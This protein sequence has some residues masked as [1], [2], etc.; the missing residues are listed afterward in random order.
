M[1]SSTFRDLKQHR[2]AVIAAMNGEQMIPLAQ[3]FDGALPADLIKSSL[4]KVEQA[5]VYVGMIASRYGQRPYCADRN[6]Q[7]LSLTELEYRR[8]AERKLPRLMFIMADDHPLTHSDLKL[9]LEEGDEA[10]QLQQGFV[11]LVLKDGI[12]AEFSSPHDLKAQ[13]TKTFVDFLKQAIAKA[14]PAPTSTAPK[15]QVGPDETL[16]TPPPA[17]HVVRKPYVEKRVFAGRFDELALIDA[18]ATGPDTMLLLQA[19]GG[20]GKSM[21]TWHWLKNYA[22]QV[23]PNWAGQLWYSFYEHGADLNDFLVHALAYIRQC[24]PATLR[25]M[26]TL[27]LGYALRQELHAR[28]WLLIL[29]GLERVLVAYNRAG[30]EHMSDDDAEVAR[31]A[32]GLDRAPRACFRPED[33]DVLAMLA[34]AGKGKLLASSRLTPTA[35]TNE[36]QQP[37]RGVQHVALEGLAP[38]DGEQVLRTAGVC[39]DGWKMRHFLDQ[40]FAGHPLSVGTVAGQ[41]MTFIEARGDFD[42]WVDSPRGGKDPGLISGKLRGRQNHIL[43]RAF[44]DLDADQQALLGSLAMANVELVP[45]VVRLLNPM[46]PIKPRTMKEPKA[47]NNETLYGS[48]NDPVIDAAFNEWLQAE[49][50]EAREAANTRLQAFRIA[51]LDKQQQD[52]DAYLAAVKNWQ[53][54]VVPA[55]GWLERALPELESR[56]LVQYDGASGALDMHPAIRHTA[57]LGLSPDI[58]SRTGS[59]VSDSLSSRPVKPFEEAHTRDDLALPITRVEALNAA[60]KFAEGWELLQSSE[61]LDALFRLHLAHEAL[62]LLQ[63]YFPEGWETGP[64]A[65]PEES[66]VDALESAAVFLRW[67]GRPQTALTVRI[68]AT[69]L[70]L[71]LDDPDAGQLFNIAV[72]LES[73]GKRSHADRVEALAF[74]LAE[75]SG[76]DTTWFTAERARRFCTAGRLQEAETLLAPLRT[77]AEARELSDSNEARV[78]TVDLVL[79]CL[80]GDLSE[81]IAVPKLARIQALGQRFLETESMPVF[82]AW[83]QTHG[84]HQIALETF[85]DLIAL[86]N[87]LGLPDL[88]AYEA[89]RALSLVSLGRTDDARRIADKVDTGRSP[90]RSTLAL[91]YLALGDHD[92][93]RVH[94]LSGYRQAWGEGPPYHHNWDLEDCR[95]V[96]VAVGE[97]QPQLPPFDPMKVEPFDFEPAVERLIEKKLAKKAER[98]AEKAKRDATQ[99]ARTAPAQAPG[100]SADAEIRTG[101]SPV[102]PD[103]VTRA[104]G[105]TAIAPEWVV[106]PADVEGAR[107]IETRRETHIF[108]LN[109]GRFYLDG[110]IAVATLELARATIDELVKPRR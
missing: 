29:D 86:A 22:S 27:D 102:T 70:R 99:N 41:I 50:Q 72:V 40:N 19:I 57:L 74:Q 53:L 58:R 106:A 18:W 43:S 95:K 31:D 33:D 88:P 63:A 107:Y 69:D 36:A 52:Y 46:R 60:G 12:T 35:L 14:S 71:K 84:R 34:Q 109:D 77:Q 5:D 23:R 3:E 100:A 17:F 45:E 56:G 62:E 37:I 78:L 13:A 64:V 20:M 48:T 25:R 10:R 24:P 75:V 2:L 68:H 55:D 110:T 42:R 89:R 92:K 94:A 83:H 76:E 7:R 103:T 97:P 1:L 15:T 4:D 67:S 73:L 80:N 93:A 51:D 30:K 44:D 82:A 96:L 21:L 16:P 8:A 65:L 85:S 11:A 81:P 105:T 108:A 32:M 47:K 101:N 98:E 91:L 59:H 54:Q 39:G 38:E 79:A 61:L 104:V 87:K 66:R 6:P 90:P 28:P 9:S 49:T 26:R